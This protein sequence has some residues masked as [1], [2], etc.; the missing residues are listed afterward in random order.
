MPDHPQ[1]L[2]WCRQALQ[3]D[4]A[5]AEALVEHHHRPLFA[6]LRRLCG[7]KP[8]ACDLTQQTFG[9]AWQSLDKFRGAST[10]STWLHRIAYCTYVDWVRRQRPA[11]TMP[12]AWWETLPA[13][14]PSPLEALAAADFARRLYALVETLDPECRRA[15]VHLHY[16]QHLT[17]AETAEVLALP[18]ST[19]KHHLRS[20]VDDLRRQLA[21]PAQPAAPLST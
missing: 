14:E 4:R 16:Y 2:T 18:L 1:S 12:E 5:A 10:V 13:A 9:K 21:I 19:L 11:G 20:A 15:A 3:G 8:D 17:L 6:F 7:N